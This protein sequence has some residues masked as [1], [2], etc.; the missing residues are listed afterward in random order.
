M[1]DL[2][3]LQGLKAFHEA[4]TQEEARLA[5]EDKC[6]R[7]DVKKMFA[8]AIQKD[9]SC[10]FLLREESYRCYHRFLTTTEMI[11]LGLTL[12]WICDRPATLLHPTYRDYGRY[13]ELDNQYRDLYGT[14]AYEVILQHIELEQE[15][16]GH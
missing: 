12:K 14:H 10:Q 6:M 7:A 4:R 1:S 16:E 11:E 15:Q 2:E 8:V 3:S 5:K 13:Y 9:P